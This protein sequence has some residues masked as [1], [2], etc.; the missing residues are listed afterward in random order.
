MLGGILPHAGKRYDA[1]MKFWAA[2]FA[3][4][5]ALAHAA[6]APPSAADLLAK[7]GAEAARGQ[8]SVWVIFDAS[9]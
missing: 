3:V 7:A 9:W 1:A 4:G 5:L 2:L 6:D 8:R